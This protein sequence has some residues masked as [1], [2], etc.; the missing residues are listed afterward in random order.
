MNRVPRQSQEEAL[1]GDLLKTK[2]K[3]LVWDLDNTLWD[4]ILLED[5]NIVLRQGV[6][7]VVRT[8]DTR[9]IVQSIAS[10]ND[11]REAMDKLETFGLHHYFLYPQINWGTKSASVAAIAKA[12]NIGIDSLA[13]IDDDPFEREE[14]A[15][16][17]PDVLCIDAAE[18]RTVLEMPA[19]TPRFIT[20]DSARR[21]EMYQADIRRAEAQERFDGP[22]DRFL[23]SLEMCLSIAPAQEAD[24]KRAEE[25]T[26]RTNQLNTTGYT[27]SYDELDQFRKSDAHHLWVAGLDDKYGSYG[28]I[29]LALIEKGEQEW[30][31]RLLLM[32]CR[33]MSRGVGSVFIN[34]IRNRARE[35]DVRLMAEMVPNQRNRLMYLTYKFSHFRETENCEG[36]VILENDLDRTQAFPGYLR[37]NLQ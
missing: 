4:G 32:S 18:V 15:S 33:V 24:L 16:V 37:L 5:D 31:I 27:Y 26:L 3:C 9:G 1:A 11:R 25:L 21:R 28:Q 6:V 13:F 7:D 36:L 34:Y 19:M 23:A 20:A 29:G 14:V 17:H 35:A 30:W 12:L 2:V 22:Q 10:R 8:L